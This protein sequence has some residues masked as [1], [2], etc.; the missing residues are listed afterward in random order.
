[1]LADMGFVVERFG[2]RSLLARE[3][4]G[5]LAGGDPSSALRSIFDDLTEEG[6]SQTDG[7]EDVGERLLVSLACHCAIKSGQVLT[8]L[9]MH[10]L[11]ARLEASAVRSLCPHAE[12]VMVHLSESAIRKQFGRERGG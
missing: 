8:H 7:R 12:P 9:E 1:M 2:E 3:V 11:L 6:P 10:D 4:P 5:P